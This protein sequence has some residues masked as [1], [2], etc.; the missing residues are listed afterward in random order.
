MSDT[1]DLFSL[2]EICVSD[3]LTKDQLQNSVKKYELKLVLEEETGAVRLSEQPPCDTMWGKYWY[4]SGTNQ[5]MKNELRKIVEDIT[6]IV[7]HQE[8]I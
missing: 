3:F 6:S 7:N 1:I 8:E 4:R 2:G 5:T